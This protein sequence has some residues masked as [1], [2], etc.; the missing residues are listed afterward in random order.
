MPTLEE[1]AKALLFKYELAE[2]EISTLHEKNAG[3]F[4][5]LDELNTVKESARDEL[6][7]VFH[8]TSGPP[9][10]VP[11]GKR[12]HTFANSDYFRVEVTYKKKS[13]YYSPKKLPSTA[14]LIPGLVTEVDKEM[15]DKLA[16]K[17]KRVKDAL[18]TG[19]WMSPSLSI[20]RVE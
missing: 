10:Q 12:T 18:V 8:T 19:E 17:D 15:C 7:R 5:K 16:N 1:T 13:D 2:K 6:K 4:A 11:V 9:K 14:F 3:L 20:P